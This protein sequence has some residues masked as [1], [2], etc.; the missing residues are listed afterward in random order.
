LSQSRG[1]E[2]LEAGRSKGLM[3]VVWCVKNAVN[4]TRV[5]NM[6]RVGSRSRVL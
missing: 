2:A 4:Q 5:T 6:W 3:E 1:V